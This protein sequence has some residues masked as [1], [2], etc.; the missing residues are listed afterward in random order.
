MPGHHLKPNS[1]LLDKLLVAGLLGLVLYQTRGVASPGPSGVE[2]LQYLW[3]LGALLFAL[4]L[5]AIASDLIRGLHRMVRTYRA[6]NPKRSEASAKWLTVKQARKA[7]LGRFKGLFLGLMDGQPLCIANATHGL[8]CSPARKGKTTSFVIGTLCQDI[9]VSR[10][11]ADMKGEL[12]VQT[13]RL[14]AKRHGHRVLTL[15]PAQKFGLDNLSY[16]PLQIILDA[17]ESS[18][19]D[20]VADTWSLTLQLSPIPPGGEREPYWPNGTRKLMVGVFLGLCVLREANQATLPNAFVV[21]S[22]NDKLEELLTEARMSTALRDELASLAGNISATWEE[23]P[24]HFETFREGALQSLLAFGPSGRL[25]RSMQGCDFRFA[26]L[27]AQKTT[28]FMICDYSRMDVFAPWLGVLVWAALKELVRS[29]NAVPVQFLLDEFTNYKLPGLPNAMT[30]LGGYGVRLWIVVQELEEIA[31]VYGREALA[32]ILSQTDVKQFFG[33]ASLETAKHVSQLLGEEEISSEQFGLGDHLGQAPS[34]SVGTMRRPLLTPDQ[35]R[36]LPGDEQ[37]LFIENLPPARALK[38]GY[39]EV[40]P[41]RRQVANNP[42]HGN[43]RYLGRVKMRIRFGRAFATKEGLRRSPRARRAVLRPLLAAILMSIP[44]GAVVLVGAA[45]YVITS[46]GWP[47]ML[48]T[49]DPSG[50]WC[51]YVGLPFVSE[52]IVITGGDHCR[53]IAWKK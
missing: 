6:I 16:N 38:V 24:K 33:V 28:L 12:A 44:G 30:A 36:R 1:S 43:R 19:E 40:A 11:V 14:I 34:L 10:V 53:F 15:N 47:H 4:G 49:Y 18:P 29:D 8:L 48:W 39:H 32:T 20:A 45:A 31:R 35:I 26:D 3:A 2:G 52:N 51:S 25:A 41:W 42:L 5:T 27:K 37:L 17:L 50:I 22:D 21:L 23:N 9:G 7:G 13:S 46:Y